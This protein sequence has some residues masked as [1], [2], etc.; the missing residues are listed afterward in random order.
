MFNNSL[1]SEKS[2]GFVAYDILV[3][4]SLAD[5]FVVICGSVGMKGDRL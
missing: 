5:P 3:C 2:P 4:A 1:A